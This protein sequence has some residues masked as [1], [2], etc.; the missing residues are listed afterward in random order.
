MAD[1]RETNRAEIKDAWSEAGER[2]SGL[3]TKLKQH[4]AQTQGA[5]PEQTGAEVKDAVKKLGDAVQDAFEAIGAA[6]KDTGVK[7]DVRE[8][9]QSVASALGATFSGLGDELRRAFDSTS[10][11]PLGAPT[12]GSVDDGSVDDG[13]VDG[14]VDHGSVDGSVDDGAQSTPPPPEAER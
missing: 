6:A 7:Q 1:E 3:G 13:S 12:D 9:G 4:Y 8:V 5:Q 11:R 2:L 10:G 14:S